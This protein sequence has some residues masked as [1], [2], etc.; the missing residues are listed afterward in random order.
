MAVMDRLGALAAAILMLGSAPA[1]TTEGET[2]E[3]AA[4]D[5]AE[6]A[7]ESPPESELTAREIYRRVL[8]NRFETSV[9]ELK[10]VSADR[11]GNEQTVR[12]QALWKRYPQG[13]PK[14]EDG[15]LSQTVVRYMEPVDVRRTGY[16]IVNNRD[17][18]NDQF[19]Y[20]K[21]LRRIRRINL[22][23]ESIVGTD[24]S[25]EDL[26]PRELDDAE[27]LRIPDADVA[28]TPCYVV[29]ATPKP[30]MKSEYAKFWLYVERAHYVPIRIRYWDRADVEIKELRS[31]V[32]SIREIEGIWVPIEA[33]MRHLLQ[34]TET[35]L[36]V[37]VLVPNPELP[38]RFF[39]QRQLQSKRLHMPDSVMEK[40]QR[41]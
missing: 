31:R 9:Q 17:R 39:S 2:R 40:A 1:A 4:P 10:L 28:G 18:P 19:I 32:E 25:V 21:S 23:G 14:E 3:A 7:A 16:L 27:Y 37:E 30:E 35:A 5:A 41:L 13:T 34:K 20:L 15:V 11:A 6:S 8:E 24:F 36:W 33:T 26:V 38:D 12:M 22:R 29:E